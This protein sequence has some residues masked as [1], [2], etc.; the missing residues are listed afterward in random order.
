M[1]EEDYRAI[2]PKFLVDGK[3]TNPKECT[4]LEVPYKDEED[5]DILTAKD[6]ILALQGLDDLDKTPIAIALDPC[7]L[8]LRAA[9]KIGKIEPF[10]VIG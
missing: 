3:V 8:S 10:V 5:I 9:H 4:T 6:L 7:A 1:E 2:D